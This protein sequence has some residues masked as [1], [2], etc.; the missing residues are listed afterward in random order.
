MLRSSAPLLGTGWIIKN[1]FLKYRCGYCQEEIP[2]I[3]VRC[4]IC[5]DYELCLQCFA[6]GAEIGSHKNSHGYQL[7]D[8]G[9]F[10][11][12][13]SPSSSTQPG[14]W[15]AREEMS[16][17]DA[18][19]QYG[20]GNWED[21]AK[22]VETRTS[23]ETKLH[24]CERYVNGTI[25]KATW[26][27]AVTNQSSD[28][29]ARLKVVD[30]TC[31]DDGPLS[32]TITAKLPPLQIQTDE[33][34]LLGYMPHRDDFEKEHDNDA[35]LVISHLTISHA[36]DEDLDLALKLA[37]VDMYVR[38]LR[39]R[40]RRKRVVRDY[41]LALDF[42]NKKEKDK[43]APVAKKKEM[44]VDRE[45]EHKFRTLSQ[46]HTASEHEKFLQ[47]LSVER[48]LRV[49]IREL[50][51]FRRQGL[52]RVEQC[53]E[54]E[55]SRYFRERRKDQQVTTTT[56]LGSSGPAVT[57]APQPQPGG[58]NVQD[59][60]SL[61]RRLTVCQPSSEGT[62]RDCSDNRADGQETTEE[63]TGLPGYDLL[64]P[65][66]KELCRSLWLRPAHYI[67]AKTSLLLHHL[68]GSLSQPN[69]PGL[70][71]QELTVLKRFLAQSGLLSSQI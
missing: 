16:L 48:S 32:P 18:I 70:S 60:V 30:H 52:T 57:S 44:K 59:S 50:M 21:V 15:T 14:A 9:T 23:E 65:K 69:L 27:S 31:A 35:E 20:Y 58:K 49:R 26:P 34:M 68:E 13:S 45:T 51:R 6:L 54:Y 17:L 8:P 5:E 37:H 41:Q 36:E 63:L 2:G 56:K 22:H 12:F 46:F 3:R 29:E 10:R 47:N 40:T 24:Y 33:A 4:N 25:G 43:P 19:E 64:L 67:T 66:E 42:F 62:D 11:I 39:E 53:A 71:K 28:N 38:K 1:L 7:R 55:R 61:T